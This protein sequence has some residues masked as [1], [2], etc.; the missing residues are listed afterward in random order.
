LSYNRTFRSL[1]CGAPLTYLLRPVLVPTPETM[2]KDYEDIDEALVDTFFHTVSFLRADLI[3]LHC[4][5]KDL[6]TGTILYCHIQ[7]FERSLDGRAT[8]MA[9]KMPAEGPSERSRRI[10]IAYQKI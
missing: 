8:S 2:A 6:L 5:L 3:F 10:Q 4:K 1:S 9:I 7:Q